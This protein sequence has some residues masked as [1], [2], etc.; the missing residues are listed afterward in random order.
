MAVIIP[1]FTLPDIKR[2]ILYIKKKMSAKQA[3]EVRVDAL[4]NAGV[5][6]NQH[7][8]RNSKPH[9]NFFLSIHPC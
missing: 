4:H 9:K 5:N 3:V 2:M 8:D 1:M 7:T 6:S